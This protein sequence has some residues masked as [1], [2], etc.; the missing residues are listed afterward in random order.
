MLRE[1]N[2]KDKTVPSTFRKTEYKKK[3]V[4]VLKLL[5]FI[6]LLFIQTK[7]PEY[8][9][10]FGLGSRIVAAA[11]FFITI[12]LILSLSR[13]IIV[14]W[15]IRKQHQSSEFQ[16]NFVLGINR[17]TSFLSVITFV[18]M[19]FPVMGVNIK[20]FFTSISI[21][22]AA[23][24]LLS[25][26]YISNM[27]NGL[28]LMFSNQLS[29][30]DYVQIGDQKGQIVDITWLNLHLINDD[31]DLLYIP[32]TTVLSSSVINY[33]KRRIKK[34]T[35]DLELPKELIASVE[36][37]ENRLKGIAARHPKYVKEGSDQLK[38]I[39]FNKDNLL[40]KFQMVLLRFNKDTEKKMRK[41]VQR[42]I[43]E[44]IKENSPVQKSIA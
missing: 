10:R 8:Y 24:A 33:T 35:V 14:G 25:K 31:E 17:I 39:K 28:I 43:L 44:F 21:V 1:L 40:L 34:L 19:I 7:Y 30:N 38:I 3:I 15:Y 27:L 20:E 9:N 32:N 12:H 13:M 16:D 37:L 23:I 22:A 41:V 18:L 29:L 2:M 26:D 5:L 4:F 42:E 6:I 36:I 11:L